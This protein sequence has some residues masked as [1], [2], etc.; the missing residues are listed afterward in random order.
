MLSSMHMD[1]EEEFQYFDALMDH[2]IRRSPFLR[3]LR[4]STDIS[5]RP[6]T[7]RIRAAQPYLSNTLAPP[8]PLAVVDLS[9]CVSLH[10]RLP[11][12]SA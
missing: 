8:T 11:S 9:T 12:V 4:D 10:L 3:D 1:Y 6:R 7:V 2:H 5:G